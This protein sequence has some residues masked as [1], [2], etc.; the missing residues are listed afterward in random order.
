MGSA[1]ATSGDDAGCGC[2]IEAM[3]ERATSRSSVLIETL[4]GLALWRRTRRSRWGKMSRAERG[5]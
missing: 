5:H 2:K 3:Q 1:G 4:I